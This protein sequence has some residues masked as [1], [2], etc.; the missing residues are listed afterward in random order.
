VAAADR[1]VLGPIRTGLGLDRLTWSGSG[2]APIPVE[3]L[4]F[5]AGLGIDV[6]E[7]WGMTET[8]G[9]ATINTAENF[10]TGS[11]GRPHLGTEIKLAEDG[12]ILVRGPMVAL[13][14]LR[15][16]GGVEPITDADG[17]L[18]TGDIG[19]L[20]QDGFLT[21][22]DRKKELII[23][24]GGKNISPAQIENS[25]RSHPLIGQ[26]VAIGDRRPYVT[27]LIA[28]DDE[29]APAWAKARRLDLAG[30][31]PALGDLS[32]LAAHPAVLAEVQA[33]VDLANS[34]LSRSEQIKRFR[35]LPQPWTAET[36][37]LTPTLKLRRRVI[38]E[39]HGE[40]IDA[41]Y[42]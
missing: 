8:S 3:V 1:L 23:T 19:T 7:V 28:L 10:R 9:S 30:S 27:A 38:M 6:L 29:I 17:W 32:D 31:E 24:S 18:F 22:T 16:D 26:A 41:M 25:L 39:R 42:D 13:G 20:D 5:L 40:T 2:A 36:G 12:E 35:I 11:V 15:E 37:E 33:A 14:Y 21:I 34:R 4:L